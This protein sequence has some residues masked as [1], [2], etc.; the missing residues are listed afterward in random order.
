M[1]NTIDGNKEWVMVSGSQSD[2]YNK[3]HV[4]MH[5]HKNDYY[6][7]F[8]YHTK[9]CGGMWDGW[10]DGVLTSPPSG[11]CAWSNVFYNLK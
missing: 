11:A 9:W 5:M 2:L 4:L 8:V 3:P 6:L 1:Q 7:I 10:G